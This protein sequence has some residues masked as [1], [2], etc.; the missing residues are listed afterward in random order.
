MIGSVSR[1]MHNLPLQTPHLKDVPVLPQRV[2]GALH[3]LHL[4]LA[5]PVHLSERFLHLHNFFAYPHWDGA[6]EFP[7]EILRRGEM[8]RVGVGFE[9][10]GDVVAAGGDEGEDGVGSL[11]RSLVGHGVEIEHGINEDGL[12]G[13]GIGD[14]VLPGP[15]G[16]VEEGVGDG[17]LTD[18]GLE[19][20]GGEVALRGSALSQEDAAGK[21]GRCTA[22]EDR[23]RVAMLVRDGW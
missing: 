5:E 11:G 19:R 21:G 23:L 4:L 9:D 14:D 8:V 13:R 17:T 2:E 16:V 22:A 10:P 15:G 12:G 6:A 7:L 3:P 1:Q 18:V 20:D